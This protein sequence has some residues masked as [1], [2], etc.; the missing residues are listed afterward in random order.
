SIDN[1]VTVRVTENYLVAANGLSEIASNSMRYRQLQAAYILAPTPADKAKEAKTM[2]TVLEGVNHGWG[3]YN[4]TVDAG[5]ERGIADEFHAEFTDY[6]AMNEKFM[7]LVDE[8]KI[9]ESIA[10]YRGEMRTSFNKFRDHLIK[11]E[12]YQIKQAE[13]AK[14]HSVQAYSSAHLLILVALGV[15]AVLCIVA[16]WMIVSGVSTPIRAMTG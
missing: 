14:T 2:A 5:F 10:L 6:V 11:D 1:Y 9:V 12:D 13:M 4:P 8:N 7:A 3:T 15:A 16:G